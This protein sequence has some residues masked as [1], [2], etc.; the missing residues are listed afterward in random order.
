MVGFMLNG[1]DFFGRYARNTGELEAAF[2]KRSDG[3]G[4]TRPARTVTDFK[5]R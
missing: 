4:G 5:P 3:G 1:R 2:L